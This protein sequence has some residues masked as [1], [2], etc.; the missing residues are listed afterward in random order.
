MIAPIENDRSDEAVDTVA[1]LRI[2]SNSDWRRVVV[3]LFETTVE[4]KPIGFGFASKAE[5]ARPDEEMQGGIARLA[6]DLFRALDATPALIIGLE[7]EV[8]KALT[9]AFDER[10]P[11]YRVNLSSESGEGP[12]EA[13][14]RDA[15]AS[16]QRQLFRLSVPSAP[17]SDAGRVFGAVAA[18]EEPYEPLARAGKALTEALADPHAG[19][20]TKFSGVRTMIMLP[21]PSDREEVRRDAAPEATARD[22]DSDEGGDPGFARRIWALLAAPPA[23]PGGEILDPPDN[24]LEWPGELMPF[25]REGVQ[26]LIEMD[27]LLLSDD[28][29]LGKTVQAIAALR[30]LRAQGKLGPTLVVGPAGVLDQWRRE[31]AKWAPELTAIIV[32]GAANDRVWQWKA[33]TDITIASYDVLRADAGILPNLRPSGAVWSVIVLD[34]A[35]KIKNRNETS[36]AVKNIP[37][38]RSWA[39]TGTPLENDEE[40][41]ASIMEFVDHD[42]GQP[43]KRYRPGAELQGRHRALQLRRRKVDVLQDLPPK[44]ETR[45]TIPLH[46]QQ[47]NSYD[48]AEREGVVYLKSLGSEVR[49][50]HVL[51]LITRLKQIC[52]VDPGTGASSKL[53]DIAERLSTLAAQGHKALIFSQYTSDLYGVAAAA[54][55]LREF[56]PLTLTGDMPVEQRTEIVDRFRSA[57]AHKALIVSLRAGGVGLNLQE[58]SY[59]FHLDR[60]WNP[61]VERQAEDRS[62]RLGQTVPVNAIKY[63][64]ADTIEER[65]DRILQQKQA[66]FNRLVDDV[67]LDLSARMTR[68]EMLGL[69][70]LD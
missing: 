43:R 44:L 16:L 14:P 42:A 9:D 19:A 54:R 27:R 3:G 18:R 49:I 67:S 28:M 33:G 64:C 39:L 11:I 20:L 56:D 66:L 10:S 17:G 52:N 48:K 58:A 8:P 22:F 62:H 25:Q 46:A 61:A 31:I 7:A 57:E 35:Q 55:R 21:R 32:R 40:E 6:G 47:R 45:L 38:K 68:S 13:V 53:D 30:I 36:E 15:M 69:F 65:I 23:K 4:G 50:Q 60:W 1:W 24:R 34:E 59:V 12:A 37:R 70:G 2:F 5:S 29:G 41:L 26:A 51:E 63:A